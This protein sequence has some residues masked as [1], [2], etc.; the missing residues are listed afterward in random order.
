MSQRR[1]LLIASQCDQMP[2]L[3]FLP[4]LSSRFYEVMTDPLRGQCVPA[5][6]D[7]LGGGLLVDPTVAQAKD[8]LKAAWGLAAGEHTLLV[9]FVGHGV[10]FDDDFYLLTKD[11]SRVPDS[12]TAVHIV[13]LIREQNRLSGSVDG[14][15]LLLDACFSG[16]AAAGAAGRLV[17][18][19]PGGIRFE[20][21]TAAGD[22]P[23]YDGCFTRTLAGVI[24]EGLP[25]ASGRELRTHHL[26]ELLQERCPRQTPHSLAN[27]HGRDPGLWIA[28]NAAIFPST[29]PWLKSSFAPE[30][31][32]LTEYYQ[33][34]PVLARLVLRLGF[35]RCLAVVA[36]PG[37]GKSALLAA[38]ARP[39][40]SQGIVSDG[41]LHAVVF[42]AGT[43]T[44]EEVAG[45]LAEQLSKSVPGFPRCLK[46][47]ENRGVANP[48]E[49][50]GFD[51]LHR[52]VIGPL[53]LVA[54]PGLVRIALDALDQV[55]GA[56]LDAI[57]RFLDLL[58]TE[59]GLSHVRA[60]VTARPDTSLPLSAIREVIERATDEALTAYF[61]QRGVAREEL[62]V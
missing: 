33:P 57:N 24:R 4:E 29:K 14:L 46:L 53:R 7:D 56:S 6:P 13:Q 50:A 35:D 43:M 62:H 12:G 58:A 61:A 40:V 20:L 30:I 52:K 34:P 48:T 31:E 9:A 59:G 17:A 23:A 39:E 47:F 11:A 44:A 26:T 60:V 8:A 27:T 25:C 10:A 55:P 19:M 45:W 42:L 2:R 3:D 21:L 38:L 32:R 15:V 5:L 28:L 22:N 51:A 16:A 41:F 18:A 54:E 37:A 1:I 49:W 36:P